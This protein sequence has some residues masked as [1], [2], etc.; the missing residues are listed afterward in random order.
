MSVMASKSG[1]HMDIHNFDHYDTYMDGYVVHNRACDKHERYHNE[2]RGKLS[3]LSGHPTIG[4]TNIQW[5]NVAI[6]RRSGNRLLF[7]R[8]IIIGSH[9]R[10]HYN[11]STQSG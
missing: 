1:S 3:T 5:G 7:L 2:H 9:D 10:N 6:E 8:K 11:L 4:V